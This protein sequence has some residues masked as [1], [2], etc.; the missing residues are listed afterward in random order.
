MLLKIS[1]EAPTK[2]IITPKTWVL[3]VAILKT[4]SPIRTVFNGTKEFKTETTPLS[5]SVSAN[6]NRKEGKKVPINPVITIHFH[7][8][9]SIVFRDWNPIEKIN[10]ED[11]TALKLP[12][13][14]GERSKRPFFIKIKELPQVNASRKR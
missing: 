11:N 9:V 8:W 2:P 1:I 13:C 14:K 4:A 12:N 5:T 10:K 7:W 6:A 3:D